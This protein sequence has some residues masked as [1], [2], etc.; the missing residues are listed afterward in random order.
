MRCGAENLQKHCA[1]EVYNLEDGI[2]AKHLRQL[3]AKLYL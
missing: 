3:I 2:T 1:T